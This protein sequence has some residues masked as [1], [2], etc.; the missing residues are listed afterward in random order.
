MNF[1]QLWSLVSLSL[2]DFGVSVVFA[3]LETIGKDDIFEDIERTV[4]E[5]SNLKK[6][7]LSKCPEMGE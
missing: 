1:I 4:A 2:P 3:V 5:V 6:A 7:I